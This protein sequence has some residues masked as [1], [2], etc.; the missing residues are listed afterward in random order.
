MARTLT[1]ESAYAYAIQDGFDDLGSTPAWKSLEPNGIPSF[2]PEISTVSR[3]PISR[4]RQA[5]QGTTVGL[6]STV[7]IDLDIT[8]DSFIDFIESVIFTT[9]T[10]ERIQSGALFGALLADDALPT[11]LGEGWSHS[12]ITAAIPVGQL[13]F[14]RGFATAVTNGLNAVGQSS[15]TETEVVGTPGI[16]IEDLG[17]T[18]NASIETAG[19]RFT[20]LVWT[21]ATK[22]LSSALV[23][24]T[25]IGLTPGQLLYIG[26]PTTSERFPSGTAF[27]RV[28]SVTSAGIVVDKVTDDAKI[29]TGF[30]AGGD[31]SSDAV[32]LLFGRFIRNVPTD[33]SEFLKRYIEIE[34]SFPELFETTPETPVA[35]P[36]GFEYSLN[37]LPNTLVWN[38]PERDKSTA[39][40][41]LVGTD[42]EPPVNNASRK[43]NASTPAKAIG[44]TAFNTSS[45]F[46]RLRIQD[47]DETGLTIDIVSMVATFGNNVTIEEILGRLGARYINFGNFEL[48]VELVTIF[49][50]PKVL[51]RIRENTVVTLD[52]VVQNRDG[53]I[54]ID[55]PSATLGG[56]ARDNTVN[57]SVKLNI[58]ATAFEDETLGASVGVSTIPFVP[59]S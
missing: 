48:I 29:G 1:N 37:L 21:D 19:W 59:T 7:E 31:Q 50:E 20:D 12:A 13:I 36:D 23:D 18:G 38:F 56:G 30:V 10:N 40:L 17:D 42:T 57:E 46:A 33:D 55:I 39:V 51:A 49:T 15:T 2:G 52:W 3:N 47:V 41:S 35:D 16:I 27:A 34:A 44:T 43:T 45:D 54:G 8:Q 4:S 25:T 9:A 58:T 53:V 28:V 14:A 32:D 22:T 26:G 6:D 24:E 11:L 5:K